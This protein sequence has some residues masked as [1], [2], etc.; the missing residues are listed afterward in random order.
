MKRP[1][2]VKRLAFGLGFVAVFAGVALWAQELS[3]ARIVRLSF[4]EGVVSVQ[5][6]DVG[7]WST[8]PTN[9]PIQEGFKLAT[10][11]SGFA[12][13]EFENA[14]TARIGQ[15][16]VLEFTQLALLPSGAKLNRMAV[17]RGYAT[18]NVVPE[19]DDSYE[20][21]VTAGTATLTPRGKTRFRVDFEE[22]LLQVKVFKG[23]VEIMS[24]EGTGTLGKNTVLE[25]L[26]GAVEAF[27]IS[28]GI[29]K[30]A[31]D[32][33]VEERE[34]R[35]ELARHRGAPSLYSTRVSDLMWGA[36]DLMY[37]GTWASL[38]GYGYGWAPNVGIGW[39]PYTVG[40]WCWYPMFGYTWI[41]YEPWGWLPYHYGAWIYDANIG[42]CWIPTGSGVWS[43]ALVNWYQGPGWVGWAPM[44]PMLGGGIYNCPRADGC[45]AIAPEDAVRNGRPIQPGGVRWGHPTTGRSVETVDIRP[46]R[47]AMLPGSAQGAVSVSR[48]TTGEAFGRQGIPLHV[49]AAVASP[50]SAGGAAP[51]PEG[52]DPGIVFDPE[53]RQYVNNPA[54]S[55]APATAM[56]SGQVVRPAP[57]SNYPRPA[58]SGPRRADWDS[59]RVSVQRGVAPS[60]DGT[61]SHPIDQSSG[62]RASGQNISSSRSDSGARSA[63]GTSSSG[64][65][66]SSGGERGGH[67]SVSS[68]S[69]SSGRS[70]SWGGGSSGGG[71]SSGG[72]IGGGHAG[73]SS[74]GGS[75]GPAG[76]GGGGASRG[77]RH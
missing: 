68:G 64:G 34:N 38:P 40:R 56:P 48:R 27:Q 59:G 1:L 6:P 12:E 3:H 72:S 60:S 19:G 22:G 21:E 43:P 18:F 46:E 2:C 36:M 55:A 47:S 20:V 57:Q 41:S 15:N 11:E 62:S 51:R 30:D 5:R 14:S 63:V 31:W 4:T 77:P 73:G 42:W 52:S 16:T 54:G 58:A 50:G 74:S 23:S 71:R 24:P 10:G 33:W 45:V 28:Q 49:P 25:I 32:E 70:G 9:T 53:R 37:Y 7:E 69:S 76:G 13:V 39:S 75:R 65:S 17:H 26:P 67:S 8:A 29:T 61:W 35:V 44:S 66:R